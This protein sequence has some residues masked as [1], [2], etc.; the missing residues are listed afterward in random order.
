MTVVASII[1]TLRA[2]LVTAATTALAANS[3]IVSYGPGVTDAPGN[4]LM[5]GATDPFSEDL[6]ETA[7]S[8]QKWA[9]TSGS[10]YEDGAI[11]CVALAWVGESGQTG[12]QTAHEAV[13]AIVSGLADTLRTDPTVGGLQYLIVAMFGEGQNSAKEIQDDDGSLAYVVFDVRFTAYI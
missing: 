6:D 12:A 1:P 3:V 5:I 13:F 7:Q 4:F 10:R 9:D 8:T 11:S 2:A